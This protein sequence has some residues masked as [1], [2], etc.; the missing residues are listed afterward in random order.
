[1]KYIKL[2][3]NKY[4]QISCEKY[5]I[6]F[7]NI[8]TINEKEMIEIEKIL[9]SFK[10]SEISL[11][12]QVITFKYDKYDRFSTNITIYKLEDDYYL[13]RV[14]PLTIG[15]DSPNRSYYKCDQLLGLKEIILK[16]SKIL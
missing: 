9:S 14:K 12:R 15:G 5:I 11:H 3:E 8:L 7:A 10:K 16:Y 1:M 13:V 6:F 4:E 2:F